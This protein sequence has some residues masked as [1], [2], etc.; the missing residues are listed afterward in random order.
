MS[1]DGSSDSDSK[2]AKEIKHSKR[3]PPPPMNPFHKIV[4]SRSD[5]SLLNNSNTSESREVGDL[6]NENN[7]ILG[8]VPC[9]I[10]GKQIG[11]NS[12]KFHLKQCEK[13]QL[14]IKQRQKVEDEKSTASIEDQSEGRNMKKNDYSLLVYYTQCGKTRYSLS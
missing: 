11:K 3:P 13:K 1:P 14:L 4:S 6:E 12:I 5:N 10:C 7:N 9:S 2:P 8:L